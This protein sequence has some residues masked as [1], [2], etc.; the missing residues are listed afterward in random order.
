MSRKKYSTGSRSRRQIARARRRAAL[1]RRWSAIGAVAVIA[2]IAI[3]A[4]VFG[5]GESAPA[6]PTVQGA[7]EITV[8]AAYQKYQA[9]VF[10]LDV[11]EQSEWDAFH[12]PNTTHIPLG[13]L[14]DRLNELPRDEEIVVVCRSGNRSQEGRDILLRAG[15]SNVV[16]MSGGLKQW[17]ALG[18]P[19]EGTRP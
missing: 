15:F 16:S 10:L 17:S 18:Y 5:R 1:T 11:R 2:L 19:I 4:L 13:E 14:P 7:R 8:Q 6:T 12:I 3:V 9:G